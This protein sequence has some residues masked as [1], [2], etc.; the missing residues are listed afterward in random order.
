ML[1]K[2]N[3]TMLDIH[4]FGKFRKFSENSRPTDNS[5]LKLQYHEGET[6][7]ELLVKIGIEPN[8]VGELLV[9]F[10][11]AE[12]DTVIP[13]EDSRISIFPTGMV[14]LCGGQHLKGHGN[15]TKKVKSTKYYAK[16]EIQ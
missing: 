12:L 15:I 11:V 16:P 3:Y 7:K 1:L 14:L 5:T 6:V 4:L 2:F 10:A 13:R 8:N 9:N